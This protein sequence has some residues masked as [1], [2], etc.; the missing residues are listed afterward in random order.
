MLSPE[1]GGGGRV[2]PSSELVGGGRVML[3]PE[4]GGGG[5]VMLLLGDTTEGRNEADEVTANLN[6]KLK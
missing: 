4:L 5:R 1:L 6:R 3:S 2:M